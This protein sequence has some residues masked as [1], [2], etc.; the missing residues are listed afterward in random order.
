[1]YLPLHTSIHVDY[2]CPDRLNPQATKAVALG[3]TKLEALKATLLYV[4]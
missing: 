4:I 2:T 3:L 1:M